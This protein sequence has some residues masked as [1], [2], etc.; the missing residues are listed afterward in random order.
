MDVGAVT[1]YQ[2]GT[3]REH[4]AIRALESHGF[5][6]VR[7]A[8]SGGPLDIVAFGPSS[9]RC[10][11]VKSRA[12]GGVSLLELEAAKE[13]MEHLLRL[14]GVSYEVWEYRKIGRAWV[15]TVHAA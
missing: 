10:I 15:L 13:A 7:S 14:P 12:D 3:R 4:A 9:I 6:C 2:R 8:Q 5:D 11:Q 1:R